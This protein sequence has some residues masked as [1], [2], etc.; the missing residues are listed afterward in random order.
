MRS[1]GAGPGRVGVPGL[2]VTIAAGGGG[3]GPVH[4]GFRWTAPGVAMAVNQTCCFPGKE[5][6][7]A[8]G[9][10]S[11]S[12]GDDRYAASRILNSGRHREGQ[13]YCHFGSGAVRQGLAVRM[14]GSR[15]DRVADTTHESVGGPG[16]IV[17]IGPAVGGS[18]S[19]GGVVVL[20]MTGGKAVGR[21]VARLVAGAA[22][23]RGGRVPG[24]IVAA[25]AVSRPAGAIVELFIDAGAVG[26]LGKGYIV[27]LV[28]VQTIGMVDRL[29][30]SPDG[31]VMA[32]VTGYRFMGEEGTG[33]IGGGVDCAEPGEA[34]DIGSAVAAIGMAVGSGAVGIVIVIGEG[35]GG[36]GGQRTPGHVLCLVRMERLVGDQPVTGIND[37]RMTILALEI[38]LIESGAAVEVMG[39]VGIFNHGVGRVFVTAMTAAAV[40][41]QRGSPLRGIAVM[42]VDITTGAV[43]GAGCQIAGGAGIFGRGGSGGLVLCPGDPLVSGAEL[44]ADTPL[45]VG[46]VC[47]RM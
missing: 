19:G 31:V 4:G 21:P 33:S 1:M 9:N 22:V 16:R 29:A 37:A 45:D 3:I 35:S 12:P 36:A 7:G 30:V 6:V 34:G 43:G 38:K 23:D 10:N 13:T 39:T 25:M 32:L 42:A 26:K 2:V 8:V 27:V 41:R 14:L 46:A 11:G 44:P 20:A 24:R 28:D 47:G 18:R 40:G 17:D 15:I 5:V